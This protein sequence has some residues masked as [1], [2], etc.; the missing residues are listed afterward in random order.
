MALSAWAIFR[1]G[2]DRGWK[3]TP[4]V[5]SILR[6]PATREPLRLVCQGNGEVLISSSGERFPIRA[7]I[8]DLR[9]PEDLTGFNQKYNHLY[10]TIGGFYDDT[11]RVGVRLGRI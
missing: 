3:C 10:E 4:E 9:R 1:S 7:G 8:A 6:S 5:L 11:Q 2:K